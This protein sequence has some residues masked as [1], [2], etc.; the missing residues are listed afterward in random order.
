VIRPN[1]QVREFDASKS[2]GSPPRYDLVVGSLFS[3]YWMD[4]RPNR[5]ITKASD[6]REFR[7]FLE[8]VRDTLL[9]SDGI[10]M[11]L[12]VFYADERRADEQALWRAY[13]ERELDGKAAADTYLNRNPWQYYSAGQSLVTEVAMECGFNVW[14][15]ETAPGFPF[16][17]LTLAMT[18]GS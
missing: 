3:H 16:K 14:W 6:L 9:L 4:S 17:V 13:I 7:S 18:R 11:F 2:E 10:A 8:A 15:R 5:P 1:L 12:D